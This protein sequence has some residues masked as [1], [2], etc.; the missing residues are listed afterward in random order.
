M[1]DIPSQYLF[2]ALFAA[3]AVAC[4][5]VSHFLTKRRREAMS[6]EAAKLGFEYHGE[7]SIRAE[8]FTGFKLFNTGRGRNFDNVMKGEHGG[9]RTVLFDYRYTVGGGRHST[10][11][12]QT[13]GA[14]KV[15]G[16]LL[17]S[18]AMRPESVFHKIGSLL[19]YQDIDFEQNPGFSKRYLLRGEDERAI[20][21][22]F[23]RD[24]LVHFEDR[25]GWC[26]EAGG[27]WL[28]V[29]RSGKRVDPEGL[30]EFLDEASRAAAVF[31][32]R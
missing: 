1:A 4:F 20:R 13:V 29:Y 19:G 22:A 2:L 16:G 30:R 18:F 25:P 28:V 17:P 23:S 3:I 9:A 27:D 24:T 5:A 32:P 26:V 31:R 6:R 15:R 21:E 8:P 10:T 14:F 12:R 11:Y 7:K